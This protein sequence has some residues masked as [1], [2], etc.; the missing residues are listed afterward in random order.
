MRDSLTAARN[1]AA[2]LR[3]RGT[4]PRARRH[5]KQ[6]GIAA[7]KAAPDG[8]IPGFGSESNGSKAKNQAIGFF[9]TLLL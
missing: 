2:T 7:R 5:I 1:A 8:R 4:R 3:S 6:T 9:Q